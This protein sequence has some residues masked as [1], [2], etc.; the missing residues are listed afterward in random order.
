MEQTLLAVAATDSLRQ[1]GRTAHL[2]HNSVAHRVE[3][4]EK[5]LGFACTEPFGR[6]RLLLT[7]TLHRLLE[8]RKR[9]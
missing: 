2:H 9:F 8:S 6:A 5:V 7:L 4:A 3:R 1:A